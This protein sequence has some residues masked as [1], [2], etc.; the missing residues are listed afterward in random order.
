MKLFAP[1]NETISSVK[2]R[3]RKFSIEDTRDRPYRRSGNFQGSS[4]TAWPHWWEYSASRRFSMKRW[5]DAQTSGI[6]QSIGSIP[7]SMRARLTLEKQREPKKFLADN[8]EGWPQ[9]M[10]TCCGLVISVC[11]FFAASPQ[12]TYTTRVDLR[13]TTS[14]MRSVIDSQPRPR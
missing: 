3:S 7:T 9:A 12:R 2:D 10:T 13:F 1:T 11:F 5:A 14:M 8:G 4:R 6:C